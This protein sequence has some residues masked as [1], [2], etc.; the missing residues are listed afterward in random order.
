MEASV[1]H[2]HLF[3]AIAAFGVC[4]AW[5][6]Q[7]YLVPVL[8]QKSISS[9]LTG[10]YHLVLLGS[11]FLLSLSLVISFKGGTLV[12]HALAV[13]AAVGLTLT[14]ASGTWTTEL[15]ANGEKIHASLTAVTFVLAIA[16][17]LV[18]NHTASMWGITGLAIA[19]AGTTH[20]LVANASVTEKV[21]V[22][23]LCAWLVA[24]SL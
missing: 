14:G 1:N 21:G 3:L 15:G 10:P 23:G 13:A 12:Q 2:V 6:L 11:F 17:Q 9:G 7:D 20:F 19:V 24:Y 18:S 5:A 22:L 8:R 4:A 16:L